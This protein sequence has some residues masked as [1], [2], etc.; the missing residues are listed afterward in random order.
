MNANGDYLREQI[1]TARSLTTKPFGVNVM[2]LSP[3]VDEVAAIIAEEHVVVVTT[4]AGSI[5]PKHMR[6]WLDAGIKVV[7]S[8]LPSLMRAAQNAT[9]QQRSLQREKNPAGISVS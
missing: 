6:L 9:A 3:H 8:C 5:S 2:F 7:R 1:R 4:G